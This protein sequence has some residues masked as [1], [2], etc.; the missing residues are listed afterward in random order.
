M[1]SEPA[2]RPIP[3]HSART[4]RPIARL[5]LPRQAE[6]R[7]LLLCLLEDCDAGADAGARD[8]A[9]RVVGS[10]CWLHRHDCCRAC[11]V[12]A[13]S[14][15]MALDLSER[16]QNALCRAFIKELK[17]AVRREDRECEGR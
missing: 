7:H 3:A 10:L 5:A 8:Q 12:Q 9:V 2:V 4:W 17:R 1:L 15:A 13:V 11:C 14:L 16:A 6:E